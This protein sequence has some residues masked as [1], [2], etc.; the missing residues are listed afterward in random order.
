MLRAFPGPNALRWTPLPRSLL[1]FEVNKYE[2]TFSP[3]VTGMPDRAV[4]QALGPAGVMLQPQPI[5]DLGKKCFFGGSM[6]AP[7]YNNY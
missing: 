2:I 7:V 5:T 3:G 6:A 4:C 1:L